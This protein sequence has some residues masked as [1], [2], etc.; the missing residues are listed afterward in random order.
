[1]QTCPHT[2]HEPSD[3][4]SAVLLFF[5]SGQKKP[6]KKNWGGLDLLELGHA[7]EKEKEKEIG[8][9]IGIV[10]FV[11]WWNWRTYIKMEMEAET[12]TETEMGIGT[13]D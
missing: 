1:M 6:E 8:I 2:S 4:D 5:A 13:R 9:C 11:K 7:C 3:R 12:E 10:I